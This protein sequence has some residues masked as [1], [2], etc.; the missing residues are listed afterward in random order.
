MS[1]LNKFSSSKNTLSF[2]FCHKSDFAP[3]MPSVSMTAFEPSFRIKKPPKSTFLSSATICTGKFASFM[4]ANIHLP[5]TALFRT[6]CLFLPSFSKKAS[7]VCGLLKTAMSVA[8]GFMLLSS[9][10]KASFLRAFAMIPPIAK[11]AC[12]SLLL[13]FKISKCLLL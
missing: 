5:R 12:K 8:L 4:R 1:L 11:F 9:L 7:F 13:E 6:K 10:I 3:F 2:H